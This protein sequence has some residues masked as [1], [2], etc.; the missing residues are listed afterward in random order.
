MLKRED[1]DRKTAEWLEH[2]RL[3]QASGLPFAAY[4]RQSG[5]TLATAYQW[6]SRLTRAGLWHES[7]R[8]RRSDAPDR[9]PLRFA[10]VY[11]V[12]PQ[13]AGVVIA[14]FQRSMRSLTGAEKRANA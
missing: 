12:E 8:A 9:V 1:R 7:P 10:R 6:R 4:A 3:W 11:R 13:S 2:L 5:L 14:R